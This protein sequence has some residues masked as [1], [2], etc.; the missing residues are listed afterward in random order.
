MTA[1]VAQI[2]EQ[3]RVDL[4]H[5]DMLHLWEIAAAA[6]QLP[7]VLV[8]HNVESVLFRRR[9]EHA[10]SAPIRWFME[11]QLRKLQQYEI[12]ACRSADWVAAVSEADAAQIRDLAGTSRVTVVPNSVDT[13]FFRPSSGP[14]DHAHLVYVG[15]LGWA[16][17]LDAV[18]Y[19]AA[20]ILPVIRQRAPDARLT[21]VGQIPDA[22]IR[23]RFRPES[24]I[25]LAGPVEDIRPIVSRATAFI[26]PLR[27]GGGTR[28]KIL[29]ALA[30][31]KAVVSTSVGCEGLNVVHER[32]ILIADDPEYFAAQ[33]LRLIG[34]TALAERLGVAGRRC[35]EEHYQWS[36]AAELMDEVYTRAMEHRAARKQIECVE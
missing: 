36:A 2:A 33:V 27:I 32:E 6:P 18:E 29:D 7:V 23:E 35:V 31:A 26:V 5:L 10:P 28:L 13:D 17:N 21:V 9:V 4:L 8:E 30:M 24:G 12:I 14:R 16:P 34:D 15:G 1:L 3:S 11:R 25:T 19:F 22:R 20:R